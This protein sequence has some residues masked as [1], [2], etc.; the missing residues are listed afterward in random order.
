MLMESQK[1]NGCTRRCVYCW[2]FKCYSTVLDASLQSSVWRLLKSK[3]TMPQAQRDWLSTFKKINF[4][5][6]WLLGL[7]WA[8][9]TTNLGFHWAWLTLSHL[10]TD[11]TI[12]SIYLFYLIDYSMYSIQLCLYLQ[13][14]QKSINLPYL[15]FL[16]SI[17]YSP[18]LYS[19]FYQS[20]MV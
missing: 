7:L 10:S 4:C 11:E 2:L 5:V 13:C 18:I 6:L 3:H 20:S 8:R 15:Y 16:S 9:Y 1:P 19:I 17:F 12:S 14:S